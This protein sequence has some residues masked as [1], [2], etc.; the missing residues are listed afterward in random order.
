[1]RISDVSSDVCSSDL[2]GDRAGRPDGCTV[3]AEG[4]L[5]IAEVTASRV[6]RYRPDAT[7]E[8]SIELP[9]SK[10]TSVAFG[11]PDLRTLFITTMRYGLRAEDLVREPLA[12]ARLALVTDG[13]GQ[14]EPQFHG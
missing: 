13:R 10:P 11:G 5:W 12:G 7:L 8:R 14:Q 2:Y 4:H 6:S 9:L 1:M 3:D